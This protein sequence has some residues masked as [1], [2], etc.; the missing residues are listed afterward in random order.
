MARPWS[1]AGVAAKYCGLPGASVAS[2]RL[3]PSL[4]SDTWSRPSSPIDTTA[5]SPT[6]A[7]PSTDS[8]WAWPVARAYDD[9]TVVRSA[10]NAS[11]VGE[12]AHASLAMRS[13]RSGSASIW[14]RAT[15]AS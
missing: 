9:A 11:S 2:P 1:P 15:D 10:A 3:E 12:V 6:Q 4:A 7:T 14:P 8:S 13:A 5:W